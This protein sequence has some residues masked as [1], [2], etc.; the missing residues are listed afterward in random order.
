MARKRTDSELSKTPRVTRSSKRKSSISQE[1]KEDALK[2]EDSTTLAPIGE[3]NETYKSPPMVARRTRSQRSALKAKRDAAKQ[4]KKEVQEEKEESMKDNDYKIT[5]VAEV[6]TPTKYEDEASNPDPTPTLN[7]TDAPHSDEIKTPKESKSSKNVN[8]PEKSSEKRRKRSKSESSKKSYDPVASTKDNKEDVSATPTPKSTDVSLSKDAKNDIDNMPKESIS[9]KKVDTTTTTKSPRKRRNRSKS[10]SSKDD[11]ITK[12]DEKDASVTPTTKSTNESLSED[13]KNNTNDNPS[14]ESSAPVASTKDDEKNISATPTKSTDESLSEDV[15]NDTNDTLKESESSNKVDTPTKSSRKR[16]TKSKSKS[17]KEGTEDVKNNTDDTTKESESSNK[18]DTTPTKSS[19]KKRTRSKSKSSKE[20]TI[21]TTTPKATPTKSVPDSMD[22][23]GRSI[24]KRQKKSK[25]KAGTDVATTAT[26][27]PPKPSNNNRNELPSPPLPDLPTLT[28][29][30]VHVNVQRFRSTNYIPTTILRM[31][32]TPTPISDHDAKKADSYVA[33]SRQGGQVELVCPNEQWRCIVRVEGLPSRDVD[34]LVWICGS[35]SSNNT[36]NTLDGTT[37]SSPPTTSLTTTTSGS[38]ENDENITYFFK[39]HECTQEIQFQRRLFGASRD[40]TIF[41]IDL[42]SKSH[43][44]VVTS[45]GGAVYCLATLLPPR[46][47]TTTSREDDKVQTV[48]AAGC[49]D[50]CVR[51]YRIKDRENGDDPSLSSLDLISTLPSTGTAITSLVWKRGTDTDGIGGSTIYAAAGDGTIRRFDCKSS[52]SNKKISSSSISTTPHASSTG[53]V[54][55]TTYKWISTSRIT[56]GNQGGTK[57]TVVWAL[58]LLTD[59]TL[60]SADSMGMINFWDGMGGTLLQSFEHNSLSMD[61]LDI[62]VNQDETTLMATGIDPTVIFIQRAKGD[63]KWNITTKRKP[64][65][66]DVNT[67]ATVHV[68]DPDTKASKEIL[69]SGGVDTRVYAYDIADIRQNR[70]T[71]AYKYPADLP[72]SFARQSRILAVMKSTTIDFYQMEQNNPEIVK[73]AVQYDETDAYIG[74]LEYNSTHSLSCFD[75]SDDGRYLA[76][77]EARDGLTLYALDIVSNDEKKELKYEKIQIPA[78][79]ANLSCSKVKF[80]NDSRLICATPNGPIAVLQIQ[81]EN[82]VDLEHMFD[83]RI[84]ISSSASTFPVSQLTVSPDSKWFAVSRNTL[85]QGSIK[86]FSI[87]PGNYQHWWSLPSFGSPHSSIRFSDIGDDTRPSLVVTCYN[88]EF[89]IFNVREKS[90]DEWSEPKGFPVDINLPWELRHQVSNN[91]R[92]FFNPSYPHMLFMGGADWFCAINLKDQIPTRSKPFPSDHLKARPW[93][94]KI[95]R[96][97]RIKNKPTRKRKKRNDD[98]V[99]IWNDNY[100]I[101]LQYTRI[102]FM[103]F[104]SKDEML[105]V[106]QP[107][108]EIMDQL[109]NP[110][111]RHRYG[112]Y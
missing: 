14:K 67:L 57:A 80:T 58:K 107:W 68:R 93:K 55:G 33:I 20:G 10:V 18:V 88:N 103:D 15:K 81:A 21:T 51:L 8:T 96:H 61:V 13:V 12:D 59:E 22:N 9:S 38:M 19:K 94:H 85:N 25:S 89:Y 76:L 17:S 86:V 6:A 45:G 78:D 69:C 43:V 109:T 39:Q 87:S 31:C 23:P 52:T 42:K 112:S 77:S 83:N 16:R 50:G 27:P 11:A 48:L 36:P 3:Q 97:Q 72:L 95:K 64:H 4:T 111:I 35:R 47:P 79:A 98:E 91:E 73:E 26:T 56:L 84:P 63:H 53:L 105:V 24:R 101:C 106:E 49:E 29:P 37:S 110:V 108:S 90:L 75:V 32:P 65:S 100:K 74:C 60:I 92:S 62:E 104:I 30:N 40:G 66:H 102:I 34:S 54:L 2:N 82:K 99:E 44:G 5:P 46:Q 71:L 41:E 70:P 7:P 1:P 28:K